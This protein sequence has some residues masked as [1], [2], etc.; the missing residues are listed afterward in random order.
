[1]RVIESRSNEWPTQRAGTLDGPWEQA[2]YFILL[3]PVASKSNYRHSAGSGAQWAELKTFAESVRLAARAA[4]PAGWVTGAAGTALAER[5]KVVTALFARSML[6]V[7][8]LSK[9]ILD[10]VEGTPRKGR[11]PAQPGV[12]MANDAQVAGDAA[13]GVR[14]NDSPGVLIAFARLAST[15]RPSAVAT[16]TAELVLASSRHLDQ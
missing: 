9:S 5:P 6:D 8:N 2:F 14:T 1:M 13:W 11:F 3:G 7:G 15:A 10:A 4:R 12:V 16:A